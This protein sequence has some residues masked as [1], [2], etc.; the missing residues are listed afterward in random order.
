MLLLLVALVEIFRNW[1]HRRV[2]YLVQKDTDEF[3][4]PSEAEGYILYNT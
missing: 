2:P 3:I 1:Y 4:I